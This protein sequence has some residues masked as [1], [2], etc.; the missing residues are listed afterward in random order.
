MKSCGERVK[1]CGGDPSYTRTARVEP[2]S[3][4]TLVG[5]STCTSHISA[6]VIGIDGINPAFRRTT[7]S[8]TNLGLG[9]LPNPIVLPLA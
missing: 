2:L 7:P 4:S 9:E 6:K 5:Q 1:L 8:A 3:L